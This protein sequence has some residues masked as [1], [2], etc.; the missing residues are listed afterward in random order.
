M[1]C[2]A[3]TL[4]IGLLTISVSGCNQGVADTKSQAV[5]E[6]CANCGKVIAIKPV[7]A[8]AKGSGAGAIIGA[9]I[10]GIL[11]NQVGGGSG[12]TAATAAGVIGGAVAGN[13]VEKKNNESTYYVV[14]IDLDQGG[15]RTVNVNNA[16]GIAIGSEVKIVGNDIQVVAT[17]SPTRG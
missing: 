1:N 3:Y 11:G 10:G 8:E 15:E 12:K 5:S 13:E 4:L 9:A 16:V 7:T 2:L 14:T 6:D 17:R